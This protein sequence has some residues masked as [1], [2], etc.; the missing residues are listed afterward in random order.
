MKFILE[1]QLVVRHECTFNEEIIYV[2]D[3]FIQVLPPQVVFLAFDSG[4]LAFSSLLCSVAIT[5]ELERSSPQTQVKT[6]WK[7]E[8]RLFM[9]VLRFEL[10]RCLM[11]NVLAFMRRLVNGG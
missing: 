7:S 3:F 9:D 10:V 4:L 5:K 11:P 8:L 1:V 2:P 6:T